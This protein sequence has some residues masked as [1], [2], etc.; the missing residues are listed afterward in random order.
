MNSRREEQRGRQERIAT[1]TMVT[2]CIARICKP[3]TDVQRGVSLRFG[4]FGDGGRDR[5]QR[6]VVR[7]G[8]SRDLKRTSASAHTRRK[9]NNGRSP[10]TNDQHQQSIAGTSTVVGPGKYDHHRCHLSIQWKS[11]SPTLSETRHYRPTPRA[12]RGS[13]SAEEPHAQ[14]TKH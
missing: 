6:K 10:T 4:N 2:G 12:A 13:D 1:I 8:P 11:H 3:L 9:K 7:A 5:R 14:Q